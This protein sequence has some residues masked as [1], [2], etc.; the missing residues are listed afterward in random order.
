MNVNGVVVAP[1]NRV[2]DKYKQ[3][4]FSFPIEVNSLIAGGQQLLAK[5]PHISIGL[6]SVFVGAEALAATVAGKRTNCSR[7]RIRM[8]D[9]G[10]TIFRLPELETQLYCALYRAI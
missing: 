1:V 2:Y 6:G 8:D 4:S 10:A 7:R 9:C 5:G 3:C